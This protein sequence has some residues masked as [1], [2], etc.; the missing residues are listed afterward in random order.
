MPVTSLKNPLVR[1]IRSLD[2]K[3]ARRETGLFVAEGPDSLARAALCGWAPEHLVTTGK[4]PGPAAATVLQVSERVMASLSRQR[5]PPEVIAVYRQRWASGISASGS[6]V[7]LEDV[8]DPGNLG[9]IIRSADAAGASGVALL[10]ATCDPWSPECVRASMGSIFA[11]PLA[12]LVPAAFAGLCHTWPGDVIG[13]HVAGAAEF[14]RAY[15]LPALI[16]MGGEAS[17]LS[18][19]TAA[20]ATHLVRIPMRP[21]V[22]SLNLATATALMLY[23]VLKP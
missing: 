15:R 7:V 18:P 8:R 22:D 6:W 2:D 16:V 23:E 12:R 4:E 5:N 21:G 1:M 13:T 11:V 20:T 3:K 10:G 19:E 17:G 9:T 14:R